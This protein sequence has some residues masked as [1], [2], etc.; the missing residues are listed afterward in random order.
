[1]MKIINDDAL[2]RLY[3]PSASILAI[4]HRYDLTQKQISKALDYSPVRI[5][6]WVKSKQ[7]IGVTSY[8]RIMKVF[9]EFIN[10]VDYDGV[11]RNA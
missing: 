11:Y 1:M 10:R 5:N 7:P 2:H 8:R 6:R 9:P 3:S 4:M